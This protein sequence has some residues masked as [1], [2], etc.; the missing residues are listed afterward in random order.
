MTN[1]G[2]PHTT[3]PVKKKPDA[4]K[5]KKAVAKPKKWTATDL[6]PKK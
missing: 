3:G 4:K 1:G 5:G 6:L 2:H